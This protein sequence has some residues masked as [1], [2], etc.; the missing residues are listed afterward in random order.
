MTD[1]VFANLKQ[2]LNREQKRFKYLSLLFDKVNT[3]AQFT[4]NKFYHKTIKNA[5]KKN[6]I[7]NS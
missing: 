7:K 5:K 6:C 1:K 2:R 4:D 3:Y